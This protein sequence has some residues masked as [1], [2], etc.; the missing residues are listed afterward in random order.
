MTNVK[1]SPCNGSLFGFRHS[2]VIRHSSFVIMSDVQIHPTTIV[3]LGANPHP[4]L[5]LTKGEAHGLDVMRELPESQGK[6]FPPLPLHKGERI[7]VRG[8]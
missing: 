4:P 1:G 6:T 8:R 5:S 2:F 7:E 3:D